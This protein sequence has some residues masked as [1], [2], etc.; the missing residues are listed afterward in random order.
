MSGALELLEDA[1]AAHAA[2]G[3]DRDAAQHRRPRSGGRW[4]AWGAIEE[5]SSGSRAALRVARDRAA[6]RRRWVRS[7]ALS[8]ERWCSRGRLRARPAPRLET[9]LGSRRRSQ[10]PAVLSDALTYQGISVPAD[11]PVRGGSPAL[12]RRDRDRRTPRPGD[13]AGPRQHNSGNL[14][15]QWDLP[16]AA[17]Q[18]ETALALARRRGDRF[19]E[20]LAAGNLMTCDCSAGDW[21]SSS[22]R[23]RACWRSAGSPRGRVSPYPLAILHSLRGE[24][25]AA[26][27]SLDQLDAWGP[28]RRRR[29][30]SDARVD[31]HHVW[32]GRG[33]RR[34][35]A[36]GR[37][38]AAR[39]GDRDARRDQRKRAVRVARHAAGGARA[40]AAG[41]RPRAARAARRSASG[42]RPAVPARSARPRPSA[43][44]RRRRRGAMGR[45]G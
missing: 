2:A 28:Q 14:A 26:R 35:G 9:A 11:G 15:L 8:D 16:G 24:I 41:G 18:L 23:R 33:Q 4:V 44:R 39:S 29:A 13:G 40:R 22:A 21:R 30:A 1:S 31:G 6:G 19:A 42:P 32:T 34:T 43:R 27:T 10:L 38:G 5:A 20:S 17:E 7:T 37:P 3:R 25:E 45:R 36:R 12:W